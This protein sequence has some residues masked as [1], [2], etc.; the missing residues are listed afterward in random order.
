MD[1]MKRT[2]PPTSRRRFLRQGL[3]AGLAGLVSA[4]TPAAP[5]PPSPTPPPGTATPSPIP[6][7]EAAATPA[8]PVLAEKER[9]LLAVSET[10]QIARLL[11]EDALNNTPG[12]WALNGAD[13][14]SMFDKDGKLYML[15]GDSFG[16]CIP[17]TGGPGNASDWRYNTM[18]I[19]TDRDPTDGLTFDAMIT[20]RPGHAKQLL[21]RSK[22]DKTLIPTN[23]TA[24]GDRL[25]FHYMAVL[26][27]GDPGKWVLNESGL[28]YSEDEGQTWVK[29]PTVKWEGK[30]NFGQV[31][32]VKDGDFLYLFGIPGGRQGG[33]KLARVPQASVWEKSAYTYYA[34]NDDS[35]PRWSD[36]EDQATLIVSGPVGELS[37][38]WNTYLNRWIMT[39]LHEG[40]AAIV[41]REAPDL[42]GPW[43]PALSLASAQAYPGLYGAFMHPWYVENEGEYI[44][45][46]MSLWGPYAVFWMRSRLVRA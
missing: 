15:F 22:F 39:Y 46:T 28:A 40:Q 18:A 9:A 25:I 30:S 31:A 2:T 34:G 45:Y 12:K 41:I 29:H 33:V 19:I 17:G 21:A 4:C 38:M 32:L 23:G 27:W 42:W 44:Y 24:I 13:L 35:G 26:A 8:V 5:P 1:I 7:L 14:G 11:G 43:G 10:K 20:D 3:A 37:V 36:A 6:L 16:C